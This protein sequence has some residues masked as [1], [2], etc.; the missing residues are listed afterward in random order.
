MW[1]CKY[2]H[3][4][5]MKF[6]SEVSNRGGVALFSTLL[7]KNWPEVSFKRVE[8]QPKISENLWNQNFLVTCTLTY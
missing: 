7:Y 6:Y 5:F 2:L 1:T 8:K 3:N 4:F